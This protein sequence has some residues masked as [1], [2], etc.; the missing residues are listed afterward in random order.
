MRYDLWLHHCLEVR[1]YKVPLFL[2]CATLSK[3]SLA[4]SWFFQHFFQFL[5]STP[6]RI[7]TAGIEE[8]ES[9]KKLLLQGDI[10][11]AADT[12][13]DRILAK[14][15]SS[16]VQPILPPSWKQEQDVIIVAGSTWKPDEDILLEGLRVVEKD[17]PKFRSE[18]CLRYVLVPHEPTEEAVQRLQASIPDSI[19][20]SDIEEAHLVEKR[21]IIV[22]SIGKLLSLYSEADAAYVGGGFGVG[23][24]SV[25]EPAGY[26]VPLACGENIRKSR[27]ARALKNLSALTITHNDRD[28]ADWLI[29]IVKNPSKRSDDGVIARQ[30]IEGQTGWSAT[31]GDEILATM[32]QSVR[33]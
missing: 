27:D 23:V 18:V 30:Y 31:I 24:H 13:F 14:V 15:E 20:F 9:F 8:T 17:M 1:R 25:T 10:V 3:D 32:R 33:T 16:K 22:D 19:L 26:G 7:Y 21:H 29:S 28:I 4:F 5:Y 12:R 6:A 11:T 2:L